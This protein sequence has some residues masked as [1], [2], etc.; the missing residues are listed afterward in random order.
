LEKDVLEGRISPFT[1]AEKVM[2]AFSPTQDTFNSP[3]RKLQT[4]NP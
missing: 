2:A 4:E 1:A 3:D